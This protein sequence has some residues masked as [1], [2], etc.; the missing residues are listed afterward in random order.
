LPKTESQ[1][2]EA[3]MESA[4]S[5]TGI[6][7]KYS[8]ERPELGFELDSYP[9]M[10]LFRLERWATIQFM[11][12]LRLLANEETAYVAEV[13]LRGLLE[14]LAHVW[15]IQR[16]GDDGRDSRQ[17]RAIRMELG[18]AS[19]LVQTIEHT[20]PQF[21]PDG[22]AQVASDRLDHFNAVYQSAN[23]AGRAR[24]YGSVSESLVEIDNPFGFAWLHQMWNVGSMVSHQG[25]LDRIMRDIG[26]GVT[27]VGKP[28]TLA[29]RVVLLER[30]SSVYGLIGREL[31]R[32]NSPADLPSLDAVMMTFKA[33]CKELYE[34]LAAKP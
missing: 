3:A 4:F 26:N 8:G 21:V 5:M 31:L 19:E 34:R 2:F 24:K 11:G 22:S 20:P 32:T 12:L 7:T 15:W 1:I 29:E 30:A 18:M 17:C 23:C 33:N 13:V 14:N 6:A 27:V 10:T 16:G 28:A 25:L 9:E